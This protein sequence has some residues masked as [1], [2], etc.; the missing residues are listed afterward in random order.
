MGDRVGAALAAAAA[1]VLIV[2]IADIPWLP[3]GWAADSRSGSWSRRSTISAS[4]PVE[5]RLM[6][7]ASLHAGAVADAW[8]KRQ[9]GP[10]WSPEVG[11]ARRRSRSSRRATPRLARGRAR[12]R[13]DRQRRTGRG[14]RDA[15]RG[16]EGSARRRRRPLQPVGGLSR[17][18]P[19]V[20][21]SRR[22]AEGARRRRPRDRLEPSPEPYFNRALA[23]EGLGRPMPRRRPGPT[24][25]R[26]IAIPPG[27]GRPKSAGRRSG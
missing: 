26:A 21:S 15:R 23:L 3:C 10:R 22:L 9:V 27:R 4:R 25:P 24:T 13:A 19:L 6:G 12:R 1:L 8:R 17:A 7:A 2:R 16:R 18:R 14:H 11:I 20:E 5:G